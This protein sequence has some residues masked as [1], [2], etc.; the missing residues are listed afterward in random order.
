MSDKKEEFKVIDS[1]KERIVELQK[2]PDNKGKFLRIKILGGG[3]SGF[4]YNFELDSKIAKDDFVIK[5]KKTAIIVIDSVS[6]DFLKG[7]SIEFVNN[8][9]GSYFTINNPN[10]TATCG[11]GSS[12][13]V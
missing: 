9:G 5:E 10:A 13:A 2:K 7:C 11:C 6:L 1:A 8:L 3:C 4:Q 12:F